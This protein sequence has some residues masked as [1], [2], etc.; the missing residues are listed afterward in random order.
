V[1]QLAARGDTSPEIAQALFI[2][3]RTV[4]SHLARI[5]AKLGVASKRELLQRASEFGL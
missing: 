2:G 1:A 4:E 5:Y 3:E